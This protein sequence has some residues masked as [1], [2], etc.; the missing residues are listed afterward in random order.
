MIYGVLAAM[1]AD[2]LTTTRSRI[3]VRRADLWPRLLAHLRQSVCF[4]MAVS[5]A[6]VY[7]D[8][9]QYVVDALIFASLAAMRMV[10]GI[11]IGPIAEVTGLPSVDRSVERS[12][13]NELPLEVAVLDFALNAAQEHT[14]RVAVLAV[15]A[16][17]AWEARTALVML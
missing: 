11:L 15:L 13:L 14:F 6:F 4:A 8:G 1:L 2:A 7:A 9:P 17:L 12:S 3:A 10:F 16:C 5:A